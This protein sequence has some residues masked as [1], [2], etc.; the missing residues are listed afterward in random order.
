MFQNSF[1]TDFLENISISIWARESFLLQH[2]YCSR[3][4]DYACSVLSGGSEMESQ[5]LVTLHHAAALLETFVQNSSVLVQLLRSHLMEEFRC[6]HI[7]MHV[8][9]CYDNPHADHMIVTLSSTHSSLLRT[10]IT[11]AYLRQ[12]RPSPSPV[13]C[14][15]KHWNPCKVPNQKFYKGSKTDPPIPHCNVLLIL[16]Q[17]TSDK[18]P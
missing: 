3:L 8:L 12:S 17:S 16:I 2:N 1:L 5:Q 13:L 10:G 11:S 4:V 15:K 14:L 7:S 6:V 9:C 18:L